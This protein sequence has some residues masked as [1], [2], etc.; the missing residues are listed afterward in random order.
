MKISILFI[1]HRNVSL[2]GFFFHTQAFII[3]HS[4]LVKH[5]HARYFLHQIHALCSHIDLYP[6]FHIK[7][8][9]VYFYTPTS[10]CVTRGDCSASWVGPSWR[11]A[12]KIVLNA[13]HDDNQPNFHLSSIILEIKSLLKWIKISEILNLGFFFLFITTKNVETD[14]WYYK[15]FTVF[16]VQSCPTT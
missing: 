11:N 8:G 14:T 1:V 2:S 6:N 12:L 13:K 9:A 15:F 7:W 10:G 4:S 5:P 16:S 3:C